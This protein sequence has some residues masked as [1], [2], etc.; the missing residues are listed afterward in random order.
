MDIVYWI[1]L[2][3]VAGVIA[4]MIYP[5][6]SRGGIVGSIVLGIVGAIVG[7][8]IAGTFFGLATGGFNLTTMVVAVL[9]SLIVLYA[10]RF[11]RRTVS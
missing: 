2:G 4:N 3:G 7:G 10:A 8:F 5:E 11:F 9:G 1:V 6:P